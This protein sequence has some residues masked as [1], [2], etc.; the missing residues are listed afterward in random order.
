MR[1]NWLSLV[2]GISLV[3]AAGCQ[4]NADITVGSKTGEIKEAGEVPGTDSVQIGRNT[5][6]VTGEPLGSPSEP[7]T[8]EDA[9][10][11]A[12]DKPGAVAVKMG[13]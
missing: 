2:C 5:K 10:A 11:T 7:A 4:P 12:D 3:F 8:E 13:Y 9:A 6:I 1:I